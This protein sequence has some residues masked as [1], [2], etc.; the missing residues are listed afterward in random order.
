MA[1]FN[2]KRPKKQY[3]SVATIV[4]QGTVS[5]GD[6]IGNDSIHIDGEVRGNIKVNSV[7]VIG[8]TGKVTGNIKAQQIVC[9]GKLHGNVICDSMEILESGF[10]DGQIKSN[11]TLVKGSYK[12]GII[13]S[14]LFIDKG[15]FVE[16]NI[17]AKSVVNGGMLI[18]MLACR[19]LKISKSGVVRGKMF[20][21]KII[22]KGGQVEGFIG[23]YADL[24]KENP[25]LSHY[26]D[27]L[28]SHH[29]KL[30]LEPAD[31]HVDIE[32]EINNTT[33][34]N[35]ANELYL[36]VDFEIVDESTL[37]KAG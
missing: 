21:D 37:Q 22:N 36:D 17:Q 23:K 3:F 31:Y 19:V 2:N 25:V 34:S 24:M 13:C 35:P 32:E 1:F 28:N 29:D 20:A 18:G 9:S 33:D 16:S 10:I 15:A 12:G 5:I 4:T 26:A 14:G 30:L 11:K 8:K 7:V 27:V 6:F